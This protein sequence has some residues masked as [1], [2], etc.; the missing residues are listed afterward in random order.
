MEAPE[1]ERG[2]PIP[3]LVSHD[4]VSRS[5]L[6]HELEPGESRFFFA[7]ELADRNR[8]QSIAANVGQRTKR[9]YVTRTLMKEGRIGLRVWR[10]S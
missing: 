2:I 6:I 1:I 3:P 4:T 7:E 5:S 10:V 9:R 8:W